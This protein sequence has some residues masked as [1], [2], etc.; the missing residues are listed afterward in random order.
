MKRISGEKV[1]RL[2]TEKGWSQKA[3]AT[4][5]RLHP[6]TIND[7]IKAGERGSQRQ[8]S[9]IKA[10]ADAFKTTVEMLLVPSTQ[11]SISISSTPKFDAPERPSADPP[12][13]RNEIATSLNSRGS[14]SNARTE[15]HEPIAEYLAALHAR[16][17]QPLMFMLSSHEGWRDSELNVRRSLASRPDGG[18][19]RDGTPVTVRDAASDETTEPSFP[20]AMASLQQ[21]VVIQ[22]LFRPEAFQRVCVVGGAGSGKSTFLEEICCCAKHIWRQNNE[23]DSTRVPFLIPL[24]RWSEYAQPRKNPDS[25]SIADF[26]AFCTSTLNTPFILQLCE[27]G[28]AIIL[29]DGFDEVRTETQRQKLARWLDEQVS[30]SYLARCPVVLTGRA[31]ALN[32]VDLRSFR[33]RL[34]ELEPFTHKQVETYIR[35]YFGGQPVYA[36]RLIG[37]I[38]K[39]SSLFQLVRTP[40]MLTMLCFIQRD[41][42]VPPTTEG[43]MLEQALSEF[44]RRRHAQLDGGGRRGTTLLASSVSLRLL[45]GLAWKCWIDSQGFGL[46]Q[47]R[48][49]E[50]IVDLTRTDAVLKRELRRSTP[51]AALEMLVS[52][53][54]VLIPTE[55]AS[56]TFADAVLAEYLAARWLAT[57]P[58]HVITEE[59]HDHVWDPA[60][61]RVFV[62][63]AGRL[64]HGTKDQRITA[65]VLVQWLLE[66][67]DA[68]FDDH[69]GSLLSMA[70][71]LAASAEGADLVDQQLSN[72]LLDALICAWTKAA[73]SQSFK[74]EKFLR[75]SLV[76]FSSTA[77]D[78]LLKAINCVLDDDSSP[79]GRPSRASAARV[80]GLIGSSQ[81]TTALIHALNCNGDHDAIFGQVLAE[82]LG[83][84]GS[85][86]ALEFL[87]KRFV[88]QA[89]SVRVT[90]GNMPVLPEPDGFSIEPMRR[91]DPSECAK[92][93]IQALEHD[94]ESVRA[95]A[96]YYLGIL[97]LSVAVEALA[98]LV[99]HDESEH[100]RLWA[101]IA[102]VMI[103]APSAVEHFLRLTFRT[104]R[105]PRRN[106]LVEVL[107][108]LGPEMVID[109]LIEAILRPPKNEV[110]WF[111]SV[112]TEVLREI[113]LTQ[114]VDRFRQALSSSNADTR[115]RA[116]YAL[117][118]LE[119]ARVSTDLQTLAFTDPNYDVRAAA[120]AALGLIGWEGAIDALG[121]SLTNEVENESFREAAAQA[122]GLLL[123]SRRWLSHRAASW[124]ICGLRSTSRLVRMH[125]AQA[126]ALCDPV[127]V[128]AP[129]LAALGDEDPDVRKSVISS[130]GS[131]GVDQAVPAIADQLT[132]ADES[133]VCIAIEALGSIRT[134]SAARILG[135]SLAVTDRS[136]H[137]K[138]IE[139]LGN[140]GQPE[141][142]DYLALSIQDEG[143]RLL[144][145]SALGKIRS[146]EAVSVIAAALDHPDHYVREA[147]K[148]A[149]PAQESTA[150]VAAL[151]KIGEFD[152]A[153]E[154]CIRLGLALGR[155]GTTSRR[156]SMSLKADPPPNV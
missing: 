50:A 89:K 53:S 132:D 138:I 5:T 142:I 59:F 150:P 57:R 105:Q 102:I 36:A 107:R 114:S 87:A 31:E 156:E 133:I 27:T 63:M 51:A 140:C 13:C 39:T 4:E 44:L 49:L 143:T 68:R 24:E 58:H 109:P 126:L 154:L 6:D 52:H 45:S 77:S 136:L 130:L 103:R 149:L 124:L 111:P 123:R 141:A 93:L 74:Y 155:N 112:L 80:L 56:C 48:A 16:L 127:I 88:Q 73:A 95:A 7:I 70:A 65:R 71:R 108:K 147:A 33:G 137:Q 99:L 110:D 18:V 64:W 153:A 104:G 79:E 151:W 11:D 66:E 121:P 40:L 91:I 22:D 120:A 30:Q 115:G 117:A 72:Q 116:V 35:S 152:A 78:G 86:E 113:H 76:A 26:A 94:S 46:T 38:R 17:R 148:R 10:I 47:D 75:S 134:S 131:L 8:A 60:W 146:D 119:D 14:P 19:K 83:D 1:D 100:V 145:V 28:R 61:E 2:L 125:C 37:H 3:L 55:N 20:P 122:I 69:W 128:L 32:Q 101:Q 96:A 85:P 12:G 15:V 139:A 23:N 9:T 43:D 34:L 42:S 25:R 97:G 29:L 41:A 92:L 98:R 81:A 84:T 90:M 144:A 82:A 62:F 21:A 129:L 135:E 106:R 118:Q 67:H 54:G